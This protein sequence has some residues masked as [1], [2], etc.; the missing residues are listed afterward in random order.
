MHVHVN[1]HSRFLTVEV[2]DVIGNY[3]LYVNGVRLGASGSMERTHISRQDYL[4]SYD[5]PDGMIAPNGDLMLALRFAVDKATRLEDGNRAP[6][7]ADCVFL[8]VS[9]EAARNASYDAAHQNI[10]PFM[11]CGLSLMVGIVSQALYFA[12]RSQ[13]EYLAIAISLL[14]SGIKQ[15]TI[16]W[17]YLHAA[18]DLSLFPAQIALGIQNFALIEFVRLILGLQ[19]TRWLL[20]LEIVSSLAF[21]SLSFANLGLLSPAHWLAAYFVPSLTV[22]VLL[23]ALLLKGLLSG[24]REARVVLPAILIA[25]VAEC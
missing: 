6:L 12:L 1:P 2:R 21:L 25:S 7:G 18:T 9:D 3:E 19:R 10:V 11:L 4:A 22:K 20:T 23:P 15:A 17:F 14:A 16:V 24:N 5:I 8:G 13:R